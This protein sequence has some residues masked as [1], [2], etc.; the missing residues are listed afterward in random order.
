MRGGRAI[1]GLGQ[2]RPLAAEPQQRFGVVF[3]RGNPDEAVLDTD[4]EHHDVVGPRE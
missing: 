3:A 2:V 4:M 1:L